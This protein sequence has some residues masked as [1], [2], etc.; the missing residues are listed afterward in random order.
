[1]GLEAQCAC[2]WSG[3]TGM[4]KA[5]LET[6]ELIL[7]GDVKRTIPLPAIADVAVEGDELRFRAAGEELALT[8]G[9]KP[10]Q[11]WATKLT[12]PP[13]TL[14]RKL[15][16]GPE[17]RARVI[18][19][20]DDPV[21]REA[22]RDAEAVDADDAALGIAVVADEAALRHALDVHGA[23]GPL[24]LVYAKGPRAGFGEGAVRSLMRTAG[25]IDTK[26]AAVSDT[27]SAMRYHFRG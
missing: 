12:T 1:M 26:V 2:R 6:E 27:L 14:A 3:G 20:V 13:P 10:A 16:I 24:W 5:L 7:R 8:L 4:V 17:A 11:R 15:G 22:L 23:K 9:A 19:P 21:L 18:G 25:Y